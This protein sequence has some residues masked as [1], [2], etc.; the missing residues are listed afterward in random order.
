[1][2]EKTRQRIISGDKK[3]LAQ[4]RA[5]LSELKGLYSQATAQASKASFKGK[6]VRCQLDI[7]SLEARI[8]RLS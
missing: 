4:K 3:K 7:E 6:I 8:A 1:M 5:R 2:N